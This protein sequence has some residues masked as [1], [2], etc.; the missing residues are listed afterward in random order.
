MRIL[1]DENVAGHTVEALGRTGHDVTWVRTD[2]PGMP[3][4][5]V[6]ELAVTDNRIVL[7]F[8]KDFGELVFRVGLAAPPAVI[9]VRVPGTDAEA[10]TETIVRTLDSREDWA[11]HFS[12]I[13][14]DRVRM[15]PLR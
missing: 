10:T 14:P 11:G 15:T 9:L 5:S 12:V 7:T 3:D 4:D 2:N 8:D 6:L 13:E 1:A